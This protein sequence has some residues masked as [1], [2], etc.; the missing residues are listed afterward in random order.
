[1]LWFLIPLLVGFALNV[2]SAYT[3]EWSARWGERRGELV[4]AVL[5]NVLGIPVW[6]IGLILAVRTASPALFPAAPAVEVLGWLL[7]GAGSV[8][9]G[10][11]LHDLRA[12]AALPSTRDTL[13]ERGL[14]ARVRHPIHAGMF[15]VWISLVLVR[16]TAAVALAS[17]LGV[18]WTLVQ[19]GAEESDLMRRLPAYRDYMGRV[20]RFVPRA[21]R[22]ASEVR[23]RGET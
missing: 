10:L 11:A 23:G 3:A 14:Y 22:K 1:V 12:K 13:V 19:T 21:R 9:I 4:T 16:P 7:L 17:G 5:R 15:L 18:V 6:A 8:I 2:A 20:P